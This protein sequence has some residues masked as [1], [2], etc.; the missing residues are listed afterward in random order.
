MPRNSR[1]YIVA[2]T[3]ADPK[4]KNLD[5][6]AVAEDGEG[7]AECSATDLESAKSGIGLTSQSNHKSYS[8]HYPDGYELEWVN[9][10]AT[11][12]GWQRALKRNRAKS[13]S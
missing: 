10:P 4:S 3:S 13:T 6:Q 8:A 1:I 2:F 7:L 11:H 12:S 5:C 9:D